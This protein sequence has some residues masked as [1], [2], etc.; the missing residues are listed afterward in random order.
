MYLD[1]IC[2]FIVSLILIRLVKIYA[3]K[4]GL[5]D[6]PNGRSTHCSIIPRGAG[7]GFYLPL[8]FILPIFHFD[9]MLSYSWTAM[10]ILFVFIIGVLDDHHDTSPNTKFVVL[11]VATLFLSFDNIII[12]DIGTF[13]GVSISLGWFALPFTVFA[14]VG[15]TNALN[16]IDGLDGLSAT[17][18][19]IILV[20]FFFVGYEH[21]DL[22]IMVLS[23]AFISGLLAFIFYNWHPASIFMGDSG[24]LTLG[25]VIATLSIKSLAYLPA[26]S[27]L[28]IAATPILDTIIVMVRRKI[29]GRSMF[30]ADR[31]HIH[32]ILRHFFAEDTPRTVIFLGVLQAIYSLTGLQIEK[33]TNSGSLLAIFILNI[34]LLYL[35]LGAMIKRQGRKC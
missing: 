34:V 9:L 3:P 18:S 22:F 25:F 19:M 23:G 16:L 6:V 26:I 31:C 33:G 1:F 7:I 8:A 28:F 17:I 2:I 10:A 14:V 21:D 13:F 4:L 12:T 24:S 15:F 20:T 32:H 35:F 29:M 11:I 30:S 5:L 27:I